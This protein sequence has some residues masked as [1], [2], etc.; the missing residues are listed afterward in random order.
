[1]RDI[2]K[3]N[4]RGKQLAINVDFARHT[5]FL[6]DQLSLS[7]HACASLLHD[8]TTALPN[9]TAVESVEAAVEELHRRRRHG[10]DAL[11]LLLQ[12]ALASEEADAPPVYRRLDAYIR[13]DLLADH[14]GQDSLALVVL[15]EIEATGQTLIK[16]QAAKT[17]AVSAT[18]IPTTTGFCSWY[19]L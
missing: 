6:S 10:I 9:A 13:R 17:G 15:A 3:T 7:E 18:S 5:L 19:L 14:P 12:A 1:M 8:V 11:L 4:L 16:A 2:G